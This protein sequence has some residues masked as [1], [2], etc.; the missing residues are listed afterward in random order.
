MTPHSSIDDI[1][2]NQAI[3]D[4][5]KSTHVLHLNILNSESLSNEFTTDLSPGDN[6]TTWKNKD[7]QLYERE[8]I[9]VTD[10]VEGGRTVQA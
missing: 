2:L 9:K 7:K 6:M 3:K 8:N 10:I 4:T 5:K 1:T